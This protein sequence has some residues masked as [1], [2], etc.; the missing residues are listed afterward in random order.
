MTIL[1]VLMN[2]KRQTVPIQGRMLDARRII[3][4]C[5]WK[6]DQVQEW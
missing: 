1:G 5:L 4:E 2:G 3:R 6:P